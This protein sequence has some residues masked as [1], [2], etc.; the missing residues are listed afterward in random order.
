MKN[1]KK[2]TGF[3]LCFLLTPLTVYSETKPNEGIRTN[4]P[5][6]FA[7]INCKIVVSSDKTIDN[8]RIVIR[9]GVIK[10]IGEN[11]TLPADAKIWDY[12]N[13]IVYPGLIEPYLPSSLKSSK[14]K[15]DEKPEENSSP[16]SG[17]YGNKNVAKNHFDNWN[18]L[19]SPQ[20]KAID[21][22]NL[23]DKKLESLHKFGFTDALIVPEKGIFRGTSSFI[24]LGNKAINESVL[25]SDLIQHLAFEQSGWDS[26]I[27]PDSL[28][29]TIALI[30]QTFLDAFWYSKA[31]SAYNLNP[32]QKSPELNLSL[33]SLQEVIK[34]NQ[35]AMFEVDNDLD[36]F[37]AAKIAR[38]FSLKII[39]KGSGYEY[40]QV[41]F[42]KET[43]IPV[44]IPL[45][46]PQELAVEKPDEALNVSLKEMQ[47][48][49][50]A[51]EN[52]YRLY[53]A[54]IPFVFTA[55]G[56]EKPESF[57]E[58]LRA[59]IDSGLPKSAALN[60]LT[61]EPAKMLGV[62]KQ[63]GTLEKGKLAHLLVTDGDLFSEKTKIIDVWT[64]GKR[65][66]ITKQP[67]VNGAGKWKLDFKIPKA[68]SIV[69]EL[70]L[71]GDKVEGS[72][73]ADDKKVSLS[74]IN[75]EENK[76]T[77]LF[78]GKELGYPGFISLNG[79]I[80]NKVINGNGIL[81]D[82]SEFIWEALYTSEPEK[83]KAEKKVKKA[84]IPVIDIF[85]PDSTFSRK[86]L[87]Y[88]P[89]KILIKDAT[90][91]TSSSMGRLE[92][93]DIFIEK[94]KIQKIGRNLNS[95]GKILVI[96][97]YGKHVTPGLID[98]HSHTGI[99]GN[100]NEDMQ[101][102]TAEVRIGDVI[103][104]YDVAY[105]HELAGG[106]TVA[107]MLHGSANP[108]GG[109][110]VV[111]KLRW[112][113]TPEDM[114]F[115]QAPEG[116]KFA[117]GENVKQSNWGD[118]YVTRY[119]QT[120]M[121]VEQIIRDSFKAA[122]DYQN[123]W[124]EY[125]SLSSSERDRKIPPRKD[126]ELDAL[127]E[128]LNKKRLVHSHSYRQDEILMLIRIA[129]DF[130]FK[131]ATLQHVLEGYKVADIIAK[132]GAGASTFS[133]W[134][135]YKFEVYDAIPYNGAL[136]NQQGVNVSFNSDSD[137]QARRLNTEAAKAVKYGGLS[138]EEALKFVTINPAVQLQIDKYVGSLEQ[139]KDA[140]F[141]IWNG[142]PLSD[143]SACEQTWIDGRK[144]FDRD[145]NTKID[146][147]IFKERNRLIQKYLEIKNKDE[148]KEEDQKS[149]K[150]LK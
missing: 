113:R 50:V 46:F 32:L 51:S 135:G 95:S 70:K 86:E 115:T 149:D 91:W 59:A 35:T 60:A 118:N 42:L 117:L 102:V 68:K 90:V 121:G 79:Y 96:N 40:R 6:V 120:R 150:E 36:L 99:T 14:K 143:Y 133:D 100:V 34:G 73:K 107:N 101:A 31:Q 10:E 43:K 56:H 30:R 65:F 146:E 110:N 132:H 64:D 38:E 124:Q 76:L 137:E 39:A 119:P 72:L 53:Q 57:F 45:N 136:L 4:H 116:I 22:L 55:S 104:P 9:N 141:V 142:N 144:Y 128:V 47:H 127:S 97:A 2:I 7:L 114:K 83:E 28:M 33:S 138:E 130:G 5:D 126:L 92:H 26:N 87:P 18:P 54:H 77:A 1:L 106:L 13:K 23:D 49:E 81:P 58:N 82:G 78:E 74:Q 44:I 125:L 11:I 84:H 80:A 67:V 21:N 139:G 89:E 108:I 123:D 109:Q 94:G 15:D 129:E 52:P 147:Q 20:K 3:I 37:R 48:W 140:D 88:Q 19:V 145:E 29:G 148:K 69:M 12:K 131:I 25:R 134:W 66:E 62:D 41:K 93:T 17:A 27:Y 63:L 24:S 122:L 71:N 103:N 112:G 98:A 75:L 61:K 105:Y 16:Q 8:G 111:V 85:L